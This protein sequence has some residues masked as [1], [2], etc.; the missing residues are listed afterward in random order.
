[1]DVL[2]NFLKGL[3]SNQSG[4]AFVILAAVMTVLM[5][6][7]ALVT[8]IG[9][10]TVN[11]QM[12]VNLMDAS[13]LSGCQKLPDEALSVQEAMDYAQLNNF[14]PAQLTYDVSDDKKSITVSGSKVVNLAFAKVLGF[15][16]QTVS[17][18]ATAEMQPLTSYYGAAPLIIKD[19][20]ILS[21]TPGTLTTIKYGNP[22]LAPGNFGALALGGTGSSV[23]ENNIAYGYQSALRVG[24][25]VS[26]ETGDMAGPTSK[27]IKERLD[28]CHDACTYENYVTGCPRVLVIPVYKDQTFQGRSTLTIC[29]FTSFFIKNALTGPDKDTIEGYFIETIQEGETDPSQIN[30]GVT[31]PVLVK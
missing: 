21:I 22:D 23:Y 26:T 19:T 18:T 4:A 28:Q 10:I 25:D 7:T 29:G 20:T 12:M 1:M 17:A 2:K 15:Y 30:Y 5:G 31:K 24:Q 6:F 16:S 13:A 14:D 8:D 3:Y 11:R 27:G 9:L